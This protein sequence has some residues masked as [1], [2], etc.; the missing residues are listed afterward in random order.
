MRGVPKATQ[1]F[2]GPMW[3]F[4]KH[5]L[6]KCCRFLHAKNLNVKIYWGQQINPIKGDVSDSTKM[7]GESYFGHPMKINE[8]ALRDPML[9][10]V[11]LKDI[12]VMMAR[13]KSGP[14]TQNSPV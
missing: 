10:K 9:L 6:T 7:Q 8:G 2:L 11:I 12:K 1:S 5:L 3:A 4:W 13:K 14:Y